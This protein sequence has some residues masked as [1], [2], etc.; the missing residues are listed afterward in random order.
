MNILIID[1][2]TELRVQCANRFK[3]FPEE[4]LDIIQPR[5]KLVGEDEFVGHLYTSD[6]V[7]LGSGLGD[8]AFNVAR[9]IKSEEPDIHIVMFVNSNYSG[10]VIRNAHHVGIR[11]VLAEWSPQL[12][13]LQELVAIESEFKRDGRSYNGKLIVVTSPKGG[14][15]VTS[16]VAALG[17]VASLYDS[18][19]LLWDFDIDTKDLARGLS[20]FGAGSNMVG[21]WIR[22]KMPINR[23]NLEKAVS[24]VHSRGDILLPPDSY[25]EALDLVCH[26]EGVTVIERILEIARSSYDSI[27]V[28]IGGTNGP[29]IGALLHFAD[30][31]IVV[32]GECP[33]ST[34][35]AELHAARLKDW[36]GNS[37][38]IRFLLSGP[39]VSLKQFQARV[40][41]L[42]KLGSR[43]WSL[44]EIPNDPR[45]GQW[46]GSGR[47]IFSQGGRST[48]RAIKDIAYEL[49]VCRGELLDN[50]YQEDPVSNAVELL[51]NSAYNSAQIGSKA[52]ARLPFFASGSKNEDST[53][54]E[55]KIQGYSDPE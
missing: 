52:I 29:G 11:K 19:T 15:G 55:Q 13:L 18:R 21:Q 27:I 28:D 39:H 31:V 46:P 10:S 22:E 37:H 25:Q 49:G 33:F 1:I 26:V 53:V 24:P 2:N 6:V 35:A 38:K 48:R 12:D 14:A 7:I 3:D 9:K 43:A 8:R 44:P 20:V 42:L 50:H 51:Q 54:A 40:E 41:P 36:L 23:E 30:E 32:S 4:E 16:I 17:E 34:T 45:V 47:T 5:L